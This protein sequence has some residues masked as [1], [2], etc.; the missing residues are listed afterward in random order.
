MARF[1]SHP[2]IEFGSG[3]RSARRPRLGLTRDGTVFHR[4]RRSTLDIPS[5][6]ALRP[7]TTR[8]SYAVAARTNRVP[9]GGAPLPFG[10]PRARRA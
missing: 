6:R 8:F 2:T 4:P 10:L 5:V 1:V 7:Q 9:A 3:R